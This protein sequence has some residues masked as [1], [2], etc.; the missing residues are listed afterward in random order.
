MH[1]ASYREGCLETLTV[2]MD[3]QIGR[4]RAQLRSLGIADDTM[5]TYTSDVSHL[6]VLISLCSALLLRRSLPL[7]PPTDTTLHLAERPGR[8]IHP[9]L[10]RAAGRRQPW[11]DQRAS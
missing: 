5:I 7:T 4:L 2:A 10:P 8:A 6:L 11:L 1:D 9:W 3:A